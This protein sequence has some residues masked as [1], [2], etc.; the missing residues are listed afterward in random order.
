MRGRGI[1]EQDTATSLHV[2]VVNQ[3]FA[4]KFF[5]DEDPIGQ[6]FRASREN[7]TSRLYEIVGVARDARAS[8]LQTLQAR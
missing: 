1:K 3:A 2:A 6:H 5:K 4:R 7:K 8:H